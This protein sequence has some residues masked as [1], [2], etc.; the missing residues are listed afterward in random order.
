MG[1]E[2]AAD[3]P[4]AG[5]CDGL[6]VCPEDLTWLLHKAA[7]RMR[8]QLDR[9]AADAGLSDVRDW[10]VLASLS[11][12]IQCTQ[13][14]LSRLL[15]VDKT[16]L[17]AVLDRLEQRELIVRTA[18]PTDRRVRIPRITEAGRLVQSRFAADRDAAEAQMLDGIEP[19]QRALLVTLLTRIAE[20]QPAR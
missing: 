4:F 8:S 13:L 11:E 12:G 16:T 10:M 1:F 14:E 15:G 20:L 3:S 17:I 5:Q 2:Q 9:L 19:D 18:D 7:N 6:L